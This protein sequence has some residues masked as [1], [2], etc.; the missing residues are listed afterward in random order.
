MVPRQSPNFHT[1]CPLHVIDLAV[2]SVVPTQFYIIYIMTK[3]KMHTKR[4]RGAT[5]SKQIRQMLGERF[6]S[7]RRNCWL[8]VPQAAQMLQVTQRT[9]HNWE[10]G[11]TRPPFAAYKLMRLLAS[12]DLGLM[13]SKW[14]GWLLHRGKLVSPEGREFT[15][16][17]S[18]WWSLLVLR[19][20]MFST[21]REKAAENPIGRAIAPSFP[22]SI[23]YG[24]T[25]NGRA[26][27]ISPEKNQARHSATSVRAEIG[28]WRSGSAI[29][30]Q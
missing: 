30:H 16:G 22:L 1:Y 17:D 2:F 5:N 11:A 9:V 12:G 10:S 28:S 27:R 23:A 7:A 8:T 21:V 15:P 19:A 29:C 4:A 3:P 13:C 6:R 14:D 20:R 24:V 18:S 26:A 25:H